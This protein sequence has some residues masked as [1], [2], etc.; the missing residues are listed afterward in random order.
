MEVNYYT[1]D[2]HH[3]E[4]LFDAGSK[5]LTASVASHMLP[6]RRHSKGPFTL[7]VVELVQN[8][9]NLHTSYGNTDPHVV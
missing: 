6:L 3:N 4:L 8:N 7:C 9:D 1:I 5:T 2:Y